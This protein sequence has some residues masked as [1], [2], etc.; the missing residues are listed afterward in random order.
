MQVFVVGSFVV[1]CSVKVARLPRA[2]ESLDAEAFVAEP[3][4]KG[5]NLALAAHRLGAA[6]DGVFA[7]GDDAFAVLA[8]SA[9]AR[10]GLSSDMLV[11]REGSTGAGIGFVDRAGENCLAV[12]LGANRLLGAADIERAAAGLE[13]SDLVLATFESPDEPIA[14]A[15]ARARAQGIRTLLNPSPSRPI[16]P[17]ILADT[18]ILL[19]N[20]VEAADLGLDLA[21]AG[22]EVGHDAGVDALLRSGPDMLIVTLG[23][24]GAVLL[25][26]G[27]APCRQTAF[28]APVV[29]TI[30]AGDAFAAGFAVALLR[31]RPVAEALRCAAA[32]GAATIGRFGAFDAFP[33]TTEL[34]QF[35]ATAEGFG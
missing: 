31:G 22:R 34:D 7:I 16:D 35:L 28:R 33:T 25:R 27:H 21:F 19:V 30:G 24:E 11:A 5:F 20:Q 8:R 18:S 3:G 6:V 12:G 10:A 29:D 2:G 17:A 15:F 32:C 4:G 13:R 26:A 23:P 14:A 1:A 9:F